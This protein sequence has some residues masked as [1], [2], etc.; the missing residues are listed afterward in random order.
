VDAGAAQSFGLLAFLP[1][2]WLALI[3]RRARDWLVF[4]AYLAAAVAAFYFLDHYA[5]TVYSN[6]TVMIE[7]LWVVAPAHIVLAF[8]PA[9]GA[10]SWREARAARAAAKSQQPL[11]SAVPPEE[12]QQ[13]AGRTA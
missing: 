11:V 4:A 13:D 3:R 2:L 8:S 5:D 10:S 6:A 1:F 7:G 9:A 12:W